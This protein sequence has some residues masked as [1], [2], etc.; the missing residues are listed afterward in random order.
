[1]STQLRDGSTV[2]DNRLGRLVEF[3]EKSRQ[4]PIRTLVS[5]KKPRS[6]TW[7][8]FDW[9]DQ[10]PDGA[11]V[12]FAWAHELQARPKEVQNIDYDSAMSIYWSAQLRDPWAGGAY[13]D[14][15][16]RM[17]GT[18]VLAAAQ[19]LHKLGF[20]EEY[21][22]AFSLDDAL[23]AVGH[24]GPG[25]LGCYWHESMFYPDENGFV[26]PEGPIMGGHAVLVRGVNFNRREVRISNS[27]GKSW[28]K[29]GDCFMTFDDF[30]KLLM[31]NGE[32]CI[33][34]G[35]IG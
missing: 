11:C 21:R 7:R 16:P 22:W 3:D 20:F 34:V 10:G 1:M 19:H 12:G 25:V 29:D 27:W 6:Y 26:K 24:E 8:L 32:F 17:D 35:R 5:D 15:S 31:N 28:G 18:S 33:P 4:Y 23:L 30:E 2:E 14:A 9:L 13:P